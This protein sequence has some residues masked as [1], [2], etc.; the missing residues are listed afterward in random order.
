MSDE[1]QKIE[2]QCFTALYPHDN[3]W[4][5]VVKFPDGSGFC[6]SQNWASQEEAATEQIKCMPE[7]MRLIN[8]Y[9]AS[10]GASCEIRTIE[11]VE[12]KAEIEIPS[13]V[14]LTPEQRALLD[15]PVS[16]LVH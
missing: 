8:S 15:L 12:H 16:N 10:K 13:E 4:R 11:K 3:R 1:V 14:Q 5:I 9:Y 2:V 6:T 7:V